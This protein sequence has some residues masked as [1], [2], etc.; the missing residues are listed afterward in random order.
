MA[1]Q[2]LVMQSEASIHIPHA[3]RCQVLQSASIEAGRH[4]C[5]LYHERLQSVLRRSLNA[6]DGSSESS[7]SCRARANRMPACKLAS[8]TRTA[9]SC[10]QHTHDMPFVART[11]GC[12]TTISPRYHL[13]AQACCL[14]QF[15]AMAPCARAH[16]ASEPGDM[17]RQA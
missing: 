17:R 12:S 9:C 3:G 6:A 14:L 8:G 7:C 2:L 10:A 13:I 5:S 1:S 11:W 15:A 16:N 4:S